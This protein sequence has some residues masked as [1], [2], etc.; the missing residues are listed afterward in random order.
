MMYDETFLKQLDYNPVKEVY[1]KL[2]SLTQDEF[3]REEIIGRA[4]GGSVNV[5]GASAVR[6]TCSLTM[7]AL[8]DDVMITDSFW[9]YKNRFK[10]E[11]GV[12]NIIDKNYPDIIWFNMGV[13]IIT[14]FNASRSTTAIS[15]S[16]SG[17][18]KMCLLNGEVGGVI[19]SSVDFGT[20][21]IVD[22]TETGEIITRI[23]K[24][25]IY[26][27]IQEMVKTYGQEKANN[28]IIN[29]LNENSYDLWEY[30]GDA[31]MYLFLNQGKAINMTLNGDTE[32]KIQLGENEYATTTLSGF[33]EN[34]YKFYST[35]TLDANY[36][37]DATIVHYKDDYN[38]YVVKVR[39]GETAG[40]HSVP[41]TYNGTLIS[42]AG[43][44]VT[45][46]LDKIKSMLGNYEYFYD[47]NGRFVFQRQNTFMQELFSP[48]SGGAI[49]PTA[50]ETQYEY[51]FEDR[52]L[53]TQISKATNINNI[54]SS[55]NN[56]PF[57]NYITK[58]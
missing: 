49:T 17:K 1:I 37:K 41:L 3:P 24:L 43:S 44:S 9:S 53:F 15:V 47:L 38:C 32:V 18:D 2:I 42:S 25:P 22:Y 50:I 13:Y 5:D 54:I 28:I 34:G 48:I 35:N 30:Q 7:V 36:N 33:E 27:I 58:K 39:N 8:E 21:E 52:Q 31:P 6:R 40:Y 45:S 12:R 26:R 46:V 23:E 55:G 19:N 10:L 57:R 20:E 14:S 11:I 4:T 56:K 51:K 29:D 16:I